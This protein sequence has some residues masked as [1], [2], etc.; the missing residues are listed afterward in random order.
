MSEFFGGDGEYR[1]KKAEER[2]RSYR[3]FLE[4]IA[5][6]YEAAAEKAMAPAQ[7]ESAHSLWSAYAREAYRLAVG[8]LR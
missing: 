2:A 8:A 6:E 4:Q 3:S 7:G 5:K 1:L